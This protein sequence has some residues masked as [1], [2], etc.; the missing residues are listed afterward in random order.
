MPFLPDDVLDHVFSY[1][2][3]GAADETAC[4][5]SLAS[6]RFRALSSSLR[7][8]FVALV[9]PNE[10]YRFAM[11]LKARRQANPELDG[12]VIPVRHLLIWSIG[13]VEKRLWDPEEWAWEQSRIAESAGLKARIGNIFKGSKSPGT[14]NLRPSPLRPLVY[15]NGEEAMWWATRLVLEE[16]T[17]GLR[18]LGIAGAGNV[19][20][21]RLWSLLL[22]RSPH[23]EELVVS[24]LE[25]PL[26]KL[27]VNSLAKTSEDLPVLRRLHVAV[28]KTLRRSFDN[29]TELFLLASKAPTLTHLRLSGLLPNDVPELF[30]AG[31]CPLPRTVERITFQPSYTAW[32]PLP[33][34]QHVGGLHIPERRRIVEMPISVRNYLRTCTGDF[35]SRVALLDWEKGQEMMTSFY[36][37]CL[38]QAGAAVSKDLTTPLNRWDEGQIVLGK[39]M[40]E[41]LAAM[42]DEVWLI[43]CR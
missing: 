43:E 41:V 9:L 7:W 38:G 36:E 20:A 42:T 27:E 25:Y 15:L 24:M 34:C 26:N 33:Q 40:E 13:K 22:G 21:R 18:R 3:R 11:F 29:T 32:G 37:G 23:L 19:H 30:E 17:P 4:A 35:A 2:I 8:R 16:L 10:V 28:E 31:A 1:A 39:D 12:S 14:K 6:R 5:L